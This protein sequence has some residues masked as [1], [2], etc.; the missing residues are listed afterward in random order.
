MHNGAVIT[1][2][3]G[4]VGMALIHS[5]IQKEIPV[6]AI[7]HKGSARNVLL[8]ESSLLTR[9]E[10][11]ISMLSG[12][13]GSLGKGYNVFY[14]L[15]WEGTFGDSRND[16]RTQMKNIQ[17]TLDAAALAQRMGCRRFIGT[18]SQAEYGRPD[19]ILR[20]DTPAFP[21]NAYGIAK[22]CAGQLSRLACARSG[23]E[24]IW[25]RILSVYGPYDRSETM[26]SDTLR[27][28]LCSERTSFTPGGQLW[29]FLYSEDAAD[30]L[31]R[32]G[33][34]GKSG[35]VYCLGSGQEKPLREYIL[36]MKKLT[37]YRLVPGFGEIPYAQGQLMRLCADI[38]PLT[39]DTGFCPHT[40]FAEGIRKTIEWMKKNEKDQRGNTVP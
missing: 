13:D 21:E 10:T 33:T 4:A 7:C 40:D 18:G 26:V 2:P 17:Y 3:T 8:P 1:G 25:V 32:L 6:L 29:D 27:K 9:V 15:A 39:R 20:P 38:E 30:A 22:L 19:G 35:S 24:H 14:H 5:C 31:I 36:A 12:L 37:G 11:D 34:Q 23:M 28:M 16:V